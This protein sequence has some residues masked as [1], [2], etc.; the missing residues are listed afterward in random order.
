M[1]FVV[2][3]RRRPGR[4]FRLAASLRHASCQRQRVRFEQLESGPGVEGIA[5]RSETEQGSE[6]ET[7]DAEDDI[8][9]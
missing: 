1:I 4:G 6:V 3:Q 2:K 8:L 7:S 5:S 9:R